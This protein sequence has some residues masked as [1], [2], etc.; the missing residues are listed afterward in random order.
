MWIHKSENQDIQNQSCERF[1][2][3]YFVSVF[4]VVFLVCLSGAL[5]APLPYGIRPTKPTTWY[6][7]LLNCSIIAAVVAITLY[8]MRVI[9]NKRCDPLVS[10]VQ[11]DICNKCFRVKHH[12]QS[13]KCECGGT[14]EDFDKWKWID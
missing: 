10:R 14:F 9:Y 12:E 11:I 5:I 1:S 6:G 8:L 13:V 2:L 4:V 3:R 7:I